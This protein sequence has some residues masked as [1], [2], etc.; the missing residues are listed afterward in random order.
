MTIIMD[1]E[2]FVMETDKFIKEIGKMVNFMEME[3][4]VL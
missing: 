4:T 2:N 3:N 1:M